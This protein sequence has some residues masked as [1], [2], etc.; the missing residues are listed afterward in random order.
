VPAKGNMEGS[1]LYKELRL[2]HKKHLGEN[3]R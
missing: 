3:R 2:G 1:G